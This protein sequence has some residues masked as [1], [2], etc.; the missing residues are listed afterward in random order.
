MAPLEGAVTGAEGPDGA[1]GVGE[2]LDL[3]VAAPLDVGLGED[4]AVTE[5]GG[6]FG[7]GR[8]E[9]LL[10]GVEV[11]YDAHA[12]PAAARG[13]LEQEGRSAAVAAA[14]STG[15]R[16][17]TPAARISSLARVLEAMASMASGGGPIQASPA[18]ATSRAKPAFSE[19]N[20]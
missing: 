13:G 3:D 10:Q 14:G 8:V 4:L 12:A 11:P 2:D 9:G 15:S 1:V 19:R 6:R 7:G 20:P 5:G 16:S 18:A 17:G